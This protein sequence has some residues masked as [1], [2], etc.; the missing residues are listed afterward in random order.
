[1]SAT[2]FSQSLNDI[3]SG[4]AE[5]NQETALKHS[6]LEAM[7][8]DLGSPERV[9]VFK[10][11]GINSDFPYCGNG[12]L[13]M[14]RMTVEEADFEVYAEF[15]SPSDTVFCPFYEKG[16]YLIVCLDANLQ[17]IGEGLV[18]LMNDNFINAGLSQGFYGVDGNVHTQRSLC[19]L[20]G[21]MQSSFAST[22]IVVHTNKKAPLGAFFFYSI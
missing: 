20:L 9:T 12:I 14:G 22:D 2:S 18:I 3:L 19:V 17:E 8:P 15:T 11:N 5:V 21:R 6:V 7:I 13:P 10:L 1:M 4:K 16:A